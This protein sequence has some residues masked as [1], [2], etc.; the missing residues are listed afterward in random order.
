MVVNVVIPIS[1]SKGWA[2]MT[3]KTNKIKKKGGLSK[4]L[5]VLRFITS[6]LGFHQSVI[7]TKNR[8]HSM[9]KVKTL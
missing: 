5:E 3:N 6:I 9:N 4:K 1:K 7:K 8:N 2:E